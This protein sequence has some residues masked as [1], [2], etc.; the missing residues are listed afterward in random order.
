MV[1]ARR[2][3]V[4]FGFVLVA[5]AVA[6]TA[7]A[8]GAE[9]VGSGAEGYGLLVDVQLLPSRTPVQAGPVSWSAQDWPPGAPSPATAN[10]V[11]AGPLP[12]DGSVVN[13]VGVLTSSASA[14]GV[15]AAV[16]TAEVHDVSLLKSGDASRVTADVVKAQANS[17][18][19]TNPNADGTTFV[20]L[21]VDGVPIEGTP[22]PNTVID[23]GVARV[24]LN[25][26]HP[27]SDGRGIV[28]NAIHV[29]STTSG[30]PLLRGDVI[31]S[32]AMSTVR[33]NNGAGSTGAANL[34]QIVKTVTPSTS[35]A[36]GQVTY[37][38]TITNNAAEDCLVNR[39]VDHL[40]PGFSLVSTAGDLGATA[41]TAPR[42][43]GAI[44]VSVGNGVT[45]GAGKSVS[46]TFVVKVG[47]SVAP[48][49]Y[50]NDVE[51]FCANLGDFIKGLDAPVTV[52]AAKVPASNA[53]QGATALP[54]APRELPKT[55]GAPPALLAA[56]ALFIGLA[57]RRT[58]SHAA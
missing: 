45:I 32:H 6:A 11:S 22:E 58:R 2:V 5:G 41:T 36:G 55:G 30:D 19:S 18:C 13:H 3:A 10:V 48:G 15:P 37:S 43:G 12:A 16:A 44:D 38:A 20:N 24:I 57:L 40:P 31:V 26:Q 9:A 25:E 47:D 7:P 50:F 33:C 8:Q 34:V 28:V 1:K 17:D 27:A 4:L 14:T 51:V 56:L 39:V 35:E 21:I 46:Q 23:L 42:P 49:T 29:I 52:T 54:S 53:V